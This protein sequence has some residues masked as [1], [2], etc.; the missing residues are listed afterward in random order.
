M[1]ERKDVI[2]Y[3]VKKN[4][5]NSYLEIGLYGAP[6][7]F[8]D[9][10]CEIKNSVDPN[11]RANAEFCTTSDHFFEDIENDLSS[12]LPDFKWDII[13]IDGDH[14]HETVDRDVPNALNHL[15]EGGTIIMH[16]CA[17]GEGPTPANSRG[18]DVWKSWV[19]LRC[20]RSDLKMNV[21]NIDWGVGVIQRGSQEVWD[22]EPLETCLT[23]EYFTSLVD[24]NSTNP[25]DSYDLSLNGQFLANNSCVYSVDD[26]LTRT[27]LLP[28][29]TEDEFYKIY[30]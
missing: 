30:E 13:F 3:F 16:D 10:R 14:Y 9:I 5:Y 29:V 21:I 20:T 15:S 11:P 2:N 8:N 24:N 6:R 26:N 27:K 18:T 12:I 22:K 19:K 28:L 25:L 23:E 1:N 7:T 4:G 17:Y